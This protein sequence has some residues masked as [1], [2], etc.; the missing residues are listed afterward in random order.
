MRQH[1]ELDNLLQ[2][3]LLHVRLPDPA[4][5]LQLFREPVHDPL[6]VDM[7]QRLRHNRLGVA[8]ARSLLEA[9]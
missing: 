6:V 4:R 9:P 1:Q 7:P 8:P 3:P 2:I 5:P